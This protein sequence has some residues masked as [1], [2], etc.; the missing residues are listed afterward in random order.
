MGAENNVGMAVV[1]ATSAIAK[2]C[3]FAQAGQLGR[4]ALC[5]R[6]EHELAALEAELR[7]RHPGLA[8]RTWIHR[9]EDVEDAASIWEQMALFCG[10]VDQA[11]VAPGMLGRQEGMEADPLLAARL[12]AVNSAGPTAWALLMAQTLERQ[13]SGALAIITSVAG[14][15]GRASNYVYGSS[16]AQLIVLAQGL[17]CRLG[18]AG[19]RVVDFRPG[20]VET[21]MTAGMKKGILM[22]RAQDVGQA[23]A[24]ALDRKDGVVYSS[25][26]WMA[27]MAAIKM[28]PFSIFR[29]MKI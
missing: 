5:A 20:M 14:M 25:L 13:R 19:V 28:I 1:G 17:R 22:A 11:L 12:L 15:R 7:A 24:T 8:V 26:A 4:L 2:E 29:K 3:I 9:L 27:I 10:R 6:G 16:K 23:L 21:P 18:G